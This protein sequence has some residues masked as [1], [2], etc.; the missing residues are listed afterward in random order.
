MPICK[1]LNKLN[2]IFRDM[3]IKL[4]SLAVEKGT[5]LIINET[6]RTDDVQEAYY[7][8]GRKPLKIVNELRQAAGLY[9]LTD[10]KENKIITNVQHV[11]TES[12]HGAGL[13]VDLVP[14]G[15]WNSP[16]EKWDI[17][18]ECIAELWIFYADFIRK[19][20]V[21]IIWGGTWKLAGGTYDQPHVE[22]KYNNKV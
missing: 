2:Y 19:N 3:V 6:L 7:A 14:D 18:G 10:E 8:Q 12:G 22:M 21:S 9:L 20:N 13:A 11:N 17:I 1:D 16:P 4:K 15:K 5:N